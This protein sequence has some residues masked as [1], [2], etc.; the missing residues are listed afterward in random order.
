[1]IA[2]LNQLEKWLANN[3][4]KTHLLPIRAAGY[5]FLFFTLMISNFIAV[6]RWPF[7]AIRRRVT[8]EKNPEES[9]V[10]QNEINEVDAEQLE[11]LLQNQELV[12]IDFWAEWC[13][14]CIMMNKPL[15]KFAES[16]GTD[17]TIAKVDTV[18]HKEIAENY[19]VKGLP[20]LLLIKNNQ[21]IKR[22]AGALSYLELRNFV[23][24]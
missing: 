6:I 5:L 23:N 15:Q 8:L 18:K 16:K 3:K 20:T 21:E 12:L 14:P 2:Q 24:N 1:M 22:Y 7:A 13:G 11:E 9:Q 4:S 19:N 17:C 10:Q